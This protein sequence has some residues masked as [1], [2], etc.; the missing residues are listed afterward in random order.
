MNDSRKHKKDVY[1]LSF[2]KKFKEA[3]SDKAKGELITVNPENVWDSIEF[4]SG[5]DNTEISIKAIW[6]QDDRIFIRTASG[7][8]RSMPLEWFPRLSNASSAEREQFELSPFG[9]DWPDLDEDL[10]FEGFYTYTKPHK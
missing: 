2:E 1:S 8:E 6:F 9:I 10:S 5:Q 7:E 3:R 4:G